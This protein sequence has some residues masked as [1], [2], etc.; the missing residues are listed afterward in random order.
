MKILITG[1]TYGLGKNIN[2]TMLE[3]GYHTHLIGSMDSYAHHLPTVIDDYDVFIN[4]EYR[5]TI[6]TELFEY[7]Y[8]NWKYEPKTII[9]ILT[10]ALI[11][12]GPNKKY[13]D[14]K[15]DLEQKTFELRTDD[16]EVRVIN[17]YPNTLESSKTVPYQKLKYS[18][19]SNI[20][21]Y[22]IELPQ[23]IEIFQIGI[24]K[25]KLKI[26]TQIL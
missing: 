7:V 25:T 9:N 20:I 3:S 21:K 4:N 17:V 1:G 23:D 26:E 15:R 14:D 10:S 16:K 12:D 5:D 22:L 13:M 8:D 19:V 2:E 6:Q 18:D 11:F 24:S